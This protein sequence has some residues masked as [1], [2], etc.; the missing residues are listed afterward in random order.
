[1]QI[2]GG[3]KYEK[4]EKGEGLGAKWGGSKEPMPGYYPDEMDN[5][6]GEGDEGER[7]RG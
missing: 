5:E 3:R 1:M 7:R 2:F 6:A 4:E